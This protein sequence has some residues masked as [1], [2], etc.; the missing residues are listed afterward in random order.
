MV[1][2]FCGGRRHP[3]ADKGKHRRHQHASLS[4]ASVQE[5]RITFGARS[6][7]E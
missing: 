2:R 4:S 6:G 1:R 3:T 7:V 5:T